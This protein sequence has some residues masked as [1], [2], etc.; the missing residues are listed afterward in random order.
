MTIIGLG[1]ASFAFLY[2][3]IFWPLKFH[4]TGCGASTAGVA[5]LPYCVFDIFYDVKRDDIRMDI[6]CDVFGNRRDHPETYLGYVRWN[7][8]YCSTAVRRSLAFKIIITLL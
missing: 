5:R 7:G 6:S 3:G 4:R 2:L 8:D 1:C